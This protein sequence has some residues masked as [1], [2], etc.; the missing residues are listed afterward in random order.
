[1]PYFVRIPKDPRLEEAFQHYLKKVCEDGNYVFF[2]VSDEEYELLKDDTRRVGRSVSGW[3]RD[4]RWRLRLTASIQ[5]RQLGIC[6]DY[7]NIE[8]RHFCILMVSM[9]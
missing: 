7:K 5:N 2:Q 4:Q 9:I 1:M 8:K 6:A 3:A